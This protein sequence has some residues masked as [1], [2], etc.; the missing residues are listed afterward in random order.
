VMRARLSPRPCCDGR[1]WSPIRSWR[2]PSVASVYREHRAPDIGQMS[3]V[4]GKNCR[5]DRV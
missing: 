1:T 3:G 5:S 4:R 2:P